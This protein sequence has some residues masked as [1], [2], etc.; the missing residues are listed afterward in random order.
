MKKLF[1]IL[2]PIFFVGCASVPTANQQVSE[3]AKK[4]DAPSA[5]NAAIYVYRSNNV[6]GAALK[7]D[8]WIDGECLGETARGTFFIKEVLGDKEHTIS[9]ESEFS[10]NHLVLKTDIGKKYFIQQSIKPGLLVGG[11]SLKQV[12]QATGEKAV[13]EYQLA[14]SGKCSKA[15]IKLD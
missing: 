13:N 14:Q 7:K 5:G 6:I 4:L 9:T 15:T 1:L 2:L 10:P 11:A 3:Q 12:D 8:V